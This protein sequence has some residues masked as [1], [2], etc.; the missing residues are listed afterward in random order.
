[1]LPERKRINPGEVGGVTKEVKIP[2]ESDRAE[3]QGEIQKVEGLLENTD[4]DSH[5]YATFVRV[6]TFYT[7]L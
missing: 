1:M 4:S 5:L 6:Y 7:S 3:I 2:I